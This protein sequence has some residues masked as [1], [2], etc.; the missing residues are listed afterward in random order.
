M[1]TP[2]KGRPAKG[3]GYSLNLYLSADRAWLRDG[4]E[5]MARR[6][7]RSLSEIVMGILEAHVKAT[8]G[9]AQPA[10]QRSSG[11][12]ERP[13]WIDEKVAGDEPK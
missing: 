13:A 5:E 11:P 3:R 10:K 1:A 12:V 7:R 8:A 9:G 4:L 6:E 2:G